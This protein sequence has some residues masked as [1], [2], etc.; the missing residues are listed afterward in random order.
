MVC[1]TLARSEYGLHKAPPPSKYEQ[2]TSF[3]FVHGIALGFGTIVTF[4]AENK[5]EKKNCKI[6]VPVC[7]IL[8]ISHVKLL[9]ISY[10][11][12]GL[13]YRLDRLKPRAAGQ[14]VYVFFDIVN[15][16]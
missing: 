6:C 13:T 5:I 9:L 7:F 8:S 4:E 11:S 1:A 12:A 16:Q 2:A 10:G 15:L 3:A 14:G